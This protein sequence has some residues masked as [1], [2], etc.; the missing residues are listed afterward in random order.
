MSPG[1]WGSASAACRSSTSRPAHQPIC[2]RGRLGRASPATARSTTSARCARARGARARVPHPLRLEV[3]AHLYEERGADCSSGCAGMFAFALWDDRAARWCWPATASASSRSTGAAGRRPRSTRSEPSAILA[4]GRR[5]ATSTSGAGSIPDPQYVPPPRDR[6][7]RRP[8]ARAGRAARLRG[9]ARSRVRRYWSLR[10]RAATTIAPSEEA[11]DELDALLAEATRLRLVADVPLGAFL[12]GGIDS[13]L[14]V[15]LHGRGRRADVQTFSIDFADAAFSEGAHARARSP[16]STAPST[17]SVARARHRRPSSTDV[18]RFAG[19]PFA[20]SSAI[21]TYCSREMT[22]RHVTVAL[23]GDG[24]DEA[25]AGYRRYSSP[26]PPT[27]R[28]RSARLPRPLARVARGRVGTPGC[29]GRTR[30]RLAAVADAARPLRRDHG[31]LRP[32]RAGGCA[33]RSSSPSGGR[34]TAWDDVLRAAGGRGVDRYLRA[35]HDH[36]PA[37]R[38]AG[39]GRPHVDGARARGPLAAARP[40]GVRVRAR[41][42]GAAEAAPR[43][44]RRCCSS[45]WLGDA[46]SRGPGRPPQAGLRHAGRRVVARTCAGGSRTCCW[47]R[48]CVVADG[49]CRPE[50]SD[51]WLS[52]STKDATIRRGCGIS[53]CS[54]P[55]IATSAIDERS[56]GPGRGS[57]RRVRDRRSSAR[58]ERTPD[59]AARRAHPWHFLPGHGR[60]PLS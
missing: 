21:P 27:A 40:R 58:R 50:S 16:S 57:S 56:G 19:E 52:T 15:E 6:L 34:R 13:S 53:R 25:F 11:L 44:A 31:A 33:D 49:L 8:Q 4:A 24:G 14:V 35:G 3:I 41:P 55:G 17:R 18:V 37:R 22:R 7:R 39:Q 45:S 26:R 28:S 10:L 60:D 12:S 36:L 48:R 43:R 54:S 59:A 51:S 20:D 32:G 1:R 23:S 29:A 42:A 47:G 38:P 30:D 5:R 9:R 46:A 2:Q